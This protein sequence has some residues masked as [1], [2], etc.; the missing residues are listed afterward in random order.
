[1]TSL[2]RYLCYPLLMATAVAATL[3]GLRSFSEAIVLPVVCV[4][5]AFV[6]A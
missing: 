2:L 5:A 4:V 6:V 1:M 3:V